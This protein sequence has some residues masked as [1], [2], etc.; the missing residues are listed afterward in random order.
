MQIK[1]KKICSPGIQLLRDLHA[2]QLSAAAP[3]FHVLTTYQR[4]NLTDTT[5]KKGPAAAQGQTNFSNDQHADNTLYNPQL[6]DHYTYSYTKF[7]ASY[8]GCKTAHDPK[9][10]RVL[11]GTI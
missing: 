6:D 1:L 5:F 2:R 11:S 7:H 9:L 10:Q 3:V 8:K 4:M